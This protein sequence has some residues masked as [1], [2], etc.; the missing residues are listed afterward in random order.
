LKSGIMLV[1]LALLFTALLIRP[2]FA[3]LEISD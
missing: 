3:L 1:K 2:Y